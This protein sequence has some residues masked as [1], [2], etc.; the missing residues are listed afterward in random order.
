MVK[1]K[2]SIHTIAPDGVFS[3]ICTIVPIF[4]RVRSCKTM[5]Q[6]EAIIE[7]L[8]QLGG[9]GELKY[10]YPKVLSLVQFKEGSDAKATI[11]NCLQTNPQDFRPSPD[12]PRGT[13]ELISF[14]E[15]ISIRDKEIARLKEENEKLRKQETANQ[16]VMKL[17]KAIMELFKRNSTIADEMRKLFLHL[18]RKEEAEL[19]DEWIEKHDKNVKIGKYFASGSMNVENIGETGKINKE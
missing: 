15:E 13:W 6:K 2:N 9:R 17:M 19:L 8:T 3:Y 16:F 18:G 4:N 14:Q 7:A 10:I 1:N 11:R 12:K 5:T